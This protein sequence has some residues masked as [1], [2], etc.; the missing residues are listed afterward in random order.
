VG[1][2]RKGG[3]HHILACSHAISTYATVCLAVTLIFASCEEDPMQN[4][5]VVSIPDTSSH[6]FV[7]DYTIIRSDEPGE[8]VFYDICYVNDTCIWAVGWFVRYGPNNERELYNACRWNGKE[9]MLEK[10]YNKTPPG[11]SIPYELT[12]LLVVH[13]DRPDNIWFSEGALFVH[14]DGKG[15]TTDLGE[16]E[17]MKGVVSECW[18][19]GANNIWMG[20]INGDL[21]HYDG[22]KWRR[23]AIPGSSEWHITGI[24]G[25]KD[26]AII[27]TTILETGPTRFYRIIKEDVQYWRA[28]SLPQGVQAVWY[29]HMNNIWTDGAQSY[30][31]DGYRWLNRHAPYAGYGQDM[32]ANN[33]ND[34]VIC[35]EV[36]TIRH[37]NGKNWKSWWKW[38]GIESARFNCITLH[39]DEVW[40]AGS[41]TAGGDLVIMHGKR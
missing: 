27:A 28:D 13:G 11:T 20:G 1:V 36:C 10:V 26:T 16:I 9:W 38:P 33:R 35:G 18:W 32:A 41:I 19:G 5:P 22:S 15:Y 37:W 17:K 40:A 2:P 8:G 7:W 14:W 29:E 24:S 21:V 34:I 39:G 31:W 3:C 12:R 30:Q 25:N 4:A 23:R 6:D